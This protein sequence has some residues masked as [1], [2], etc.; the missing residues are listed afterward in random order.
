MQNPLQF[1]FLKNQ[2]ILNGIDYK[3]N[4]YDAGPNLLYSSVPTEINIYELYVD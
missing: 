3:F 4:I 1:R 2:R